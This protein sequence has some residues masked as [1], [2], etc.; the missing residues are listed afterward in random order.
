LDNLPGLYGRVN[1]GKLGN[2]RDAAPCDL[3]VRFFSLV[4]EAESASAIIENVN[5]LPQK[6]SA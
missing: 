6:F 4:K 5:A 1:A 2:D 3:N